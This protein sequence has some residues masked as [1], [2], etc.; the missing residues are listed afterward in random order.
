LPSAACN[1]KANELHSLHH[2]VRHVGTKNPSLLLLPKPAP[3]RS[4]I[5]SHTTPQPKAF[6]AA[7]TMAHSLVQAYL[8]IPL[9]ERDAA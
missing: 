6:G 9:G 3:P 5:H 2:L 7:D 8:D 1:A 4:S